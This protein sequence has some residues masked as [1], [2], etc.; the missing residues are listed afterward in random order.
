MTISASMAAPS[1]MAMPPRLMIVAGTSNSTM[2]S[3]LSSTTSGS[4][5]AGRSALRRWSRKSR[6]NSET[7][8]PSSSSA[9]RRVSTARRI[10]LERS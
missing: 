5:R 8:S 10:R 2:G 6:M 3:T 1:A 9:I 4:E 7:A